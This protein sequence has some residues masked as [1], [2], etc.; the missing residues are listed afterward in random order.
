[1]QDTVKTTTYMP[2]VVILPA[3]LGPIFFDEEKA[4][5]EL[6]RIVKSWVEPN[7]GSQPHDSALLGRFPP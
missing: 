7:E 3:I 6:H 2:I 1:M 4:S 5:W